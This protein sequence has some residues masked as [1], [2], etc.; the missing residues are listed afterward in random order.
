MYLLL[1]DYPSF[2]EEVQIVKAT[3][4]HFEPDVKA[5]MNSEDI[6]YYQQLV[7]KVP[8]PDNVIEYAVGLAVKTRV[9]SGMAP[10]IVKQYV[11]WGAGPR[12]S[13]FLILGAKVH[14]LLN[15]KYSPDIE[16]VKAIALPVLRHRVIRNY[17]AEAEGV[18]VDTILREIL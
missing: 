16:D 8:V 7:K 17:K 13:Q 3:T 2:E 6:L 12:A 9:N 14:A 15:G 11:A 10:D 18:Q 1:V 5:V 4:G